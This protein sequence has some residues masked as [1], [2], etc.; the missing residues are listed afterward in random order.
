MYRSTRVPIRVHSYGELHIYSITALWKGVA[1]DQGL[2]EELFCEGQLVLANHEPC[3]VGV[4][5]ALVHSAKIVR[6]VASVMSLE[7]V[8]LPASS[9]V[10][11]L[12]KKAQ[13]TGCVGKTFSS[14][15]L[16]VQL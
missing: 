4:D 8:E 1:V 3:T 11:L 15:D 16:S 2:L 5:E 12:E 6:A 13:V 9:I 7:L 14:K 10:A